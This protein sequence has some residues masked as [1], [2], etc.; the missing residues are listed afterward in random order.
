MPDAEGSTSPQP[1]DLAGLGLSRLPGESAH[2]DE[3]GQ[4][5]DVGEAYDLDP[6]VSVRS[7]RF[8]AL[9]YHGRSRRLLFLRVAGLGELLAHL[10]EYSCAAELLA[11]LP[12]GEQARARAALAA[13]LGAGFLRPRMAAGP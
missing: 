6:L 8:G 10:G 3:P 9:L 12:G 2:W 5:L 11:L 13:L 7:E 4:R 1:A